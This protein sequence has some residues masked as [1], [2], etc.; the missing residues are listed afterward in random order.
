[1]RD[2]QKYLTDE[3]LQKIA[4]LIERFI[5]LFIRGQVI[6]NNKITELIQFNNYKHKL[7]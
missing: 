4:M 2:H 6:S 3:Y 5:Y 7:T 1:M